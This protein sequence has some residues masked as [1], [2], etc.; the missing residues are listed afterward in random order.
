MTTQGFET[1]K[2]QHYADARIGKG[3]KFLR[4]LRKYGDQVHWEILKDNLSREAAIEF[5]IEAIRSHDSYRSGYNS[6]EGGCGTKRKGI[7]VIGF[8][9]ETNNWVR[10]E[11]IGE[12]TRKGWNCVYHIIAGSKSYQTEKG[13]FFWK[14]GESGPLSKIPLK[15]LPIIATHLETGNTFFIQTMRQLI[16]AGFR[17]RSINTVIRKELK[18]HKGYSFR[19]ADER[20]IKANFFKMKTIPNPE[21]TC[22]G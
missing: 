17:N 20:E 21:G 1:R 9:P 11:D 5:E 14:E 2:S 22:N 8:N 4:A 13:Y 6:T 10:F 3:Y 16:N 12:A 15:N 18:S 19:Y 7:A